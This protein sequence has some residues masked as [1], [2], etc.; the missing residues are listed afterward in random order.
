M[1]Q[2]GSLVECDY[3]SNYT[4]IENEDSNQLFVQG[5]SFCFPLTQVNFVTWRLN[6]ETGH[7][8]FKF[9]FGAGKEIRVKVNLTE[10]NEILSAWTNTNTNYRGNKNELENTE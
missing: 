10:V 3:L 1:T 8:W 6:D 7:Y 4:L 9:H 2:T 5:R